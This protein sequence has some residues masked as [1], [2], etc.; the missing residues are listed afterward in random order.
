MSATGHRERKVDTNHSPWEFWDRDRAGGSGGWVQWALL[1]RAGRCGQVML[2][3][4]AP[5]Q[6]SDILLNALSAALAALCS[7]V[8]CSVV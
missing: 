7:T 6:A 4:P 2:Q 5:I 1:A 8:L 3:S